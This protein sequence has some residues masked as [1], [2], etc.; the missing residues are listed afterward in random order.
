MFSDQNANSSPQGKKGQ[1][2]EVGETLK[3]AQEG[4]SS[5]AKGQSS[6]EQG[7]GQSAEDT[8]NKGSKTQ[9]Q[10][11]LPEDATIE[12]AS[13]KPLNS[14]L[15]V[16]P[17]EMTGALKP[18]GVGEE[19]SGAP[20]QESAP[21]PPPEKGVVLNEDSN[22]KDSLAEKGTPA[23][24]VSKEEQ[25]I[26]NGWTQKQAETLSIAEIYLMLGSPEKIVLEY[27]WVETQKAET[28]AG[29]LAKNLANMLQRLLHL[30]TTE[31][32]DFKTKP[33]SLRFSPF[34]CSVII[35]CIIHDFDNFWLMYVA[36]LPL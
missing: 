25:D 20:P 36:I 2:S 19:I 5:S 9:T 26:R 31:F 22:S 3:K 32:T 33:V 7:Q 1:K 21:P 13:L 4:Q 11:Q 35:F 23:T 16:L 6:S 14:D 24:G 34:S 10:R 15:Q 28:P 8:N 17:G 27:D 30:A 18:D 12:A 29:V